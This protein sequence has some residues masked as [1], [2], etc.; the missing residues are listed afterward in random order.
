MS[1]NRSFN[2]MTKSQ[3]IPKMLLECENDHH[4]LSRRVMIMVDR[5]G[6]YIDDYRLVHRLGAGA[7][8]EVYLGEHALDQSWAAI[9]VLY[10]TQENLKG[11][12]KEASTALRLRHSHIVQLRSFG[13]GPDDTPYLIMDYAPNGTLR[14][15]HPKGAHLALNTVISYLLPLASALQYAHDRRV[16]HRDVKPENALIGLSGEVLL[17]DFGIAVV[18]PI[19][20]SLSTQDLG[21]T[22]PYMAPEQIS[23]K[24]QP[25]SDQY[26]LGV[27][28]YE[29]L[30]GV[31]PFQGSQWEI[32]E[33][34]RFRPPPP[35]REKCPDLPPQA[36]EII[37]KALAKDP[38]DRFICVR[39][40]ATALA[41]SSQMHR[42]SLP[43]SSSPLPSSS[44]PIEPPPLAT[45]PDPSLLSPSSASSPGFASLPAPKRAR[46]GSISR[47]AAI[48][49]LGLTGLAAASS[50]IVWWVT[51]QDG[52]KHNA[53]QQPAVTPSS[54][55]PPGFLFF[56]YRQ[57]SG[58]VEDAAW[59]PDGKRIASASG[60][61]TVQI[62]DASTGTHLF[63]YRHHSDYVRAV[64]WSP[65]RQYIASGSWDDTVQIWDAT[66]GSPVVTH[67][68]QGRSGVNTVTWSPTGE[69]LASGGYDQIIQVWDARTGDTLFAYQGHV[70]GNSS[71]SVLTVAWSPDGKRLASGGGPDNRVHVW[72]A[73]TGGNVLYYQGNQNS[74]NRVAWSLDGKR[75]ASAGG[76]QTVR[77][78]DTN[79]GDILLTYRG[80]VDNNSG[81]LSSV[82][83]SP[84]GKRLA[85][86]D[87]AGTVHVWTASTGTGSFIYRGHHGTVN[88]VVWSPDGKRL[89]SAG[90]DKTVQVWQA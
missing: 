29:W 38:Q 52:G 61:Q 77:I 49:G 47:R 2:E 89:A 27:M 70:G 48:V 8:G 75:L 79:T 84:D 24:P 17:S 45:T 54:T 60:D 30:C 15:R 22:V 83:W 81:G 37:L 80:H 86:S 23:G 19:E 58:F 44:L 42:F 64:A 59:S 41:G 66:N 63:T 90:D 68:L 72:D 35:L 33:Q 18:A 43:I 46:E 88:S 4:V 71:F 25:A 82:A 1:H 7:F 28:V 51:S 78:W 10:L 87:H 56:T 76:D 13:I 50:G 73:S 31:R 14:E 74:V 62:W 57:H 20:R 36:E 6:Q 21:G 53:S 12:I 69:R 67:K 9:K 34:Q 3:I 26:A 85:S 32:L 40:F 55:F 5:I 39:D 11:F 16:V 65:H